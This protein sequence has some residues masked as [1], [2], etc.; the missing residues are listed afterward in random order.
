M[1]LFLSFFFDL[2]FMEQTYDF[3]SWKHW[4]TYV[5]MDEI[6]PN[7][8]SSFGFVPWVNAI[9]DLSKNVTG[10]SKEVNDFIRELLP[11]TKLLSL[12][13]V[14]KQGESEL[15]RK[16][17]KNW[18]QF[19]FAYVSLRV[20]SHIAAKWGI[21]LGREPFFQFVKR[22]SLPVEETRNFLGVFLEIPVGFTPWKKT[23]PFYYLK[24]IYA[25]NRW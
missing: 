23:T 21:L 3:S 13:F 7:F 17:R 19:K 11:L 16:R 5:P 14:Q 20:R 8:D 4:W 22:R 12:A 2:S 10:I 9:E 1:D 18:K 25:L 15:S 6:R 24:K